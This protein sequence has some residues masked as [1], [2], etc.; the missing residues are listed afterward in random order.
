MCPAHR[1]GLSGW[2][3]ALVLT[4][5]TVGLMATLTFTIG[6]ML[7]C[8]VA[9]LA[10]AAVVAEQVGPAREDPL[11]DDDLVTH[12]QAQRRPRIF[13]RSVAIG[14]L[15]AA[16]F[17]TRRWSLVGALVGAAPLG[18]WL[19]FR[20][21][22][23]VSH[24]GPEQLSRAALGRRLMPV[25]LAIV[26]PVAAVWVVE[27]HVPSAKHTPTAQWLEYNLVRGKIHQHAAFRGL[28]HRAPQLLKTNGWSQDDWLTFWNWLYVDESRFPLKKLQRL[29]DSGGI[30]VSVKATFA[31]YLKRTLS[32]GQAPKLGIAALG[33]LIFG[34][35]GFFGGRPVLLFSGAYLAFFAFLSVALPTFARFPYHVSQPM[36][37]VVAASVWTIG[38]MEWDA[39]EYATTTLLRLRSAVLGGL[40]LLGTAVPFMQT[41]PTYL[42]DR[43][44]Q[45]K[46][47]L[48]HDRVG[49]RYRD[50]AFVLVYGGGGAVA[51]DPLDAAP[52]PYEY[53]GAGWSIFSVP[54]YR[55]LQRLGVSRGSEL[56]GAMVDNPKAFVVTDKWRTKHLLKHFSGSGKPWQL[57]EHDGEGSGPMRVVL[58]QVVAAGR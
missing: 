49:Q 3:A 31:A 29:R 25:I 33:C 15:L 56:F 26:V 28:E 54:F 45:E 22:K 51:M 43:S 37:V 10:G 12:D 11:T 4:G 24:S 20:V 9:L 7:A 5:A 44:A 2:I 57:V 47:R 46:R 21:W 36:L 18:L 35:F 17:L 50:G 23:S 16:G 41:W 48:F 6:A 55:G 42:P 13:G 30:A 52:R 53:T 8:G 39:P 34:M 38:R 14:L 1:R 32:D 40:L 19:G 27:D 58:L